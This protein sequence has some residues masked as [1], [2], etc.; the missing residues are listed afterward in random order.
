MEEAPTR[1]FSLCPLWPF[2]YSLCSC[3]AVLW[4]S[5]LPLWVLSHL[6]QHG[7]LVQALWVTFFLR[8]PS[9]TWVFLSNSNSGTTVSR[10]HPAWLNSLALGE[11]SLWEDASLITECLSPQGLWKP[12]SDVFL[13]RREVP[14]M[15][16]EGMG[17]P[18]H[19]PDLPPSICRVGRGVGFLEICNELIAI[20]KMG[21]AK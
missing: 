21:L 11:A 3:P 4:D 2:V 18:V 20:C 17:L 16:G 9:E 7:F 12:A 1:S 6:S 8:S 19:S 5:Q 13:G 15:A 10:L 14:V